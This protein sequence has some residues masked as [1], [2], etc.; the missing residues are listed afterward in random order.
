LIS[1][2]IV[3]TVTE[4]EREVAIPTRHWH[5]DTVIILEN[6]SDNTHMW[7]VGVEDWH[8][9]YTRHTFNLKC[10]CYIDYHFIK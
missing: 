10:Q 2:K 6:E 3:Y 5:A 1:K 9:S 8:M 4:R 7:Y